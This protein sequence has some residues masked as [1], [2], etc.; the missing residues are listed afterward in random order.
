[1]L[2]EISLIFGIELFK[3][4]NTKYIFM[5]LVML[6]F[7]ICTNAQKK[8]NSFKTS[9]TFYQTTYVQIDVKEK[10]DITIEIFDQ[11]KTKSVYRQIIKDVTSKGFKIYLKSLNK[12]NYYIQFKNIEGTILEEFSIKK[13]Q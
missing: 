8:E 7:S 3:T 5:L 10:Q 9:E 13:I 11:S 6:F 12:G 2:T 4:M 1:M